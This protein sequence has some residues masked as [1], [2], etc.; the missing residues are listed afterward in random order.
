MERRLGSGVVARRYTVVM[1][2]TVSRSAVISSIALA[3]LTLGTFW[4]LREYGP[5]ST[6]R[7]FH[8]A[9][10][11]G[12]ERDIADAVTSQSSP[13]AVRLLARL[14]FE[15]AR[16]EGRYQLAGVEPHGEGRVIAEVNYLFP[17]R[18][19]MVTMLW[20]V[21]R[22]AGRWRINADETARINMP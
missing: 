5:A 2:G 1:R 10:L 21:D 4:I 6:L 17:N 19:M 7:R 20:V 15:R 13:L 14:V 11:S 16:L 18:G 9:V 12:S 3:A 8:V 22:E